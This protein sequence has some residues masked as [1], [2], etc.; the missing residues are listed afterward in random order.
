MTNRKVGLLFDPQQVVALVKQEAIS[1]RRLLLSR[2][3][4]VKYYEE[5]SIQYIFE[6]PV[7][8]MVLC[9]MGEGM[10]LLCARGAW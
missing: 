10:L 5:V 1:A 4:C 2:D 3:E 9:F 8:H 6:L 7:G